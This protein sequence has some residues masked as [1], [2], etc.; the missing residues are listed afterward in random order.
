M[1]ELK[2]YAII[3]ETDAPQPNMVVQWIHGRGY[4]YLDRSKREFDGMQGWGEVTDIREFGF[5]FAEDIDGM[6]RFYRNDLAPTATYH[7][8]VPRRWQSER[9][10]FEWRILK[11]KDTVRKIERDNT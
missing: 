1:T 3:N 8:G 9:D 11:L 4:C 2:R 10:S 5:S 7:D 6:V